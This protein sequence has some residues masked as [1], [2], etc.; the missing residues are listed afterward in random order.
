VLLERIG[1]KQ[2]PFLEADRRGIGDTLDD[3]VAGILDR[4]G[5]GRV[6]AG[7]RG[8]RAPRASGPAGLVGPFVVMEVAEVMEGPLLGRQSGAGRANGFAR[9]RL[10]HPLMGAVLLRVGRENALV[11]DA[12]AQPPD[13]EL[14]QAVDPSVANG[15]PLSVR[16]ALGKRCSRKS[17]SNTGR[18][19]CPLVESRP[20]HASR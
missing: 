18:T 7:G 11:L 10:V 4:R 17:R 20:W 2:E 13:V 16:I 1:D 8:G 6:Q 9:Q 12:E 14:G 19:P 15:T 3:K 5:V